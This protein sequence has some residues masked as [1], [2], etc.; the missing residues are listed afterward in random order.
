MLEISELTI[1][2]IGSCTFAS[3]NRILQDINYYIKPKIM[4]E[5][6]VKFLFNGKFT[7]LYRHRQ[8]GKSTTTYTVKKWLEDK[9]NKE[10]YI[11]TFSSGIMV[12]K[13]LNKF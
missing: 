3:F 7:L 2:C 5:K 10:V 12:D 6:L 11:I 13:D 8:S 9:Y 4:I 1:F